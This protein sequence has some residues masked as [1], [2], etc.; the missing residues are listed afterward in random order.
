MKKLTV[1]RHGKAQPRN[2]S[3]I[4]DR[5][6]SLQKRGRKDSRSMGEF[7]AGM[8]CDLILS[9]GAVRAFETA[10]LFADGAGYEDKIQ[11]D[12]RIYSGSLNDLIKLLSE[13]Q[14]GHVVIVGHNPFISDF[15]SA[16]DGRN[17]RS[18]V[19]DPYLVTAATAHIVFEELA[20]WRD[21]HENSGQLRA[22]MS[23]RFLK[24]F[25]G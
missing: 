21:L 17:N 15:I 22:L 13:Q 1:M 14:G 8:E 12:D 18:I 4:P 5:E 2:P 20:D 25:N 16:L 7:Y 6:R 19:K 24:D 11:I 3:V 10:T 23:P 9:S